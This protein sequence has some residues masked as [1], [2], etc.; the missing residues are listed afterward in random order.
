MS[1]N[2]CNWNVARLI[3]S[4][5]RERWNVVAAVV[6]DRR[7]VFGGTDSLIVGF[8][9]G[10]AADVFSRWIENP[11]NLHCLRKGVFDQGGACGAYSEVRLRK[12]AENSARRE[13]GS[14]PRWASIA[15][16]GPGDGGACIPKSDES[17]PETNTRERAG[18]FQTTGTVS[19]R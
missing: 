9:G 13:R 6:A 4:G 15:I 8:V 17:C 1:A 19:R 18:K 11:S 12:S 16:I 14:K 3:W 7:G 2:F 10:D 5:Q